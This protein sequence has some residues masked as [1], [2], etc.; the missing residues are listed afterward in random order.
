MAKV[1]NIIMV[2]LSLAEPNQP[3]MIELI[4]VHARRSVRGKPA[5]ARA[6][7]PQPLPHVL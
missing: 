2:D 4:E 7:A 5:A 3:K 6:L 1:K